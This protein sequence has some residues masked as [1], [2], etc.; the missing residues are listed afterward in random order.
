MHMMTYSLYAYDQVRRLV[1]IQY[2]YSVY[3]F[4]FEAFYNVMNKFL[5]HTEAMKIGWSS[6]ASSIYTSII[7]RNLTWSPTVV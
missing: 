5:I 4:P 1:V 3:N 2:L 6:I 7:I